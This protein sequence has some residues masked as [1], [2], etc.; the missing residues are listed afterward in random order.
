MMARP[1][2]AFTSGVYGSKLT[3]VIDYVAYVVFEFG[4]WVLLIHKKYKK[5]WMFWCAVAVMLVIPIYKMSGP[6]DLLMRGSM[7]PLFTICLY[8]VMFVTDSFN[9]MMEKGNTN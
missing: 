3:M 8:A 6:N 2:A 4:L 1:P 5:D 9:E 7:A